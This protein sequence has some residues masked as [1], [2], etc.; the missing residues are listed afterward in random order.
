[1]LDDRSTVSGAVILA[2]PMG[3]AAE[4]ENQAEGQNGNNAADQGAARL[5]PTAAARSGGAEGRHR[6]LDVAARAPGHRNIRVRG[7]VGHERGV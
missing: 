7:R 4:Q 6:S 2:R 1:M 5:L 3:D